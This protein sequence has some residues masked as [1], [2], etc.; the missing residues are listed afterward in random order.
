MKQTAVLHKVAKR[1]K[2]LRKIKKMTQETLAG[3]ADLHPTLIGKIERAEINPTIASL[4]KI[5][6]AFNIS[7]AELLTFPDDRNII[8]VDVLV[9]DKAT[10][11][12]KQVIEIANRY[13]SMK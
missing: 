7:L 11:I 1:I 2:E 5:A 12:L 4:Q 3:K 13:K 8:D 10:E 6:K 9:L